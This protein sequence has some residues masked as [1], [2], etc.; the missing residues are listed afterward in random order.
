MKTIPLTRGKVAL[1]DDED[2][3]WLNRFKWCA[4]K[5]GN[6]W[7]ATREFNL[8]A[9]NG[10]SRSYHMTMAVF[11]IGTNRKLRIDH[12]NRN[13]LDNRKSNLRWATSG[14]NSVNWWRE[15]SN[16]YGRGVFKNKYGTFQA[17]IKPKIDEHY[18]LGSFKNA[19]DAR[20]AYDAAAV[21]F[22]GKFAMLNRDH[23][24]KKGQE[25]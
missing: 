17:H 9:T 1:V 8:H 23:F 12:V 22:Y 11:L 4:H 6:R 7:E 3:E 14:Q 19:K 24:Q 2:F 21:K 18:H 25:N 13:S 20:D 15:K 10:D 5:V 16:R